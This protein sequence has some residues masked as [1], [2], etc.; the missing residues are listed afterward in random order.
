MKNL[1]L[2]TLALLFVFSVGAQTKN[3]NLKNGLV[4]GQL[5]RSEDR[6]SVEI[7]LTELLSQNGVKAIPS[8]N[9]LKVGADVYHLENDSIIQ[10]VNQKG[11]DTYITISVRGYDKRYKLAKNHS[12]FKTAV[13]ESH[14]FPLYKDEILSISFEFTFYRNGQF[15]ATDIIRCG[16]ISSREDV[17]KQ[18]KKKLKRRITKWM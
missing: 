8:L 17:L 1:S 5:D 9:I 3:L 12:N 15:V 11:I 2:L 14:L 13:R 16:N 18:L 10:L 4:I 6:Y 7:A